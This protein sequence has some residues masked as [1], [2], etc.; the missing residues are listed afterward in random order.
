MLFLWHSSDHCQP[1]GIAGTK[2]VPF[3]SLVSGSTEL[4]EL[5]CAIWT[6]Q[7][8]LSLQKQT[9]MLGPTTIARSLLLVSLSLNHLELEMKANMTLMNWKKPQ[10]YQM[11]LCQRIVFVHVEMSWLFNWMQIPL[12]VYISIATGLSLSVSAFLF[13]EEIR[14][15]YVKCTEKQIDKKASVILS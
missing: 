1:S 9:H 13:Y 11:L 10:K 4:E 5:P 2:P 3:L 7:V 12:T 6:T 8:C 15:T 14:S